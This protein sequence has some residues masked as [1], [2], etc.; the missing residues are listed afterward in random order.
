M[1]RGFLQK[2]KGAVTKKVLERQLQD[3]PEKERELLIKLI[4]KHPDLFEKMATE[5]KAK[6]DSGVDQFTAMASVTQKYRR[7][8]AQAMQSLEDVE[9]GK[10]Q[11]INK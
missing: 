8:L 3:L 7:E 1:L 5:I 10:Q 9:D 2:A 6:I 4:E 11:V